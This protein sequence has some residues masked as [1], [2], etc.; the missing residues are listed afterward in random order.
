MSLTFVAIVTFLKKFGGWIGLVVIPTLIK[1]YN[2]NQTEI[3]SI[4]LR[5]QKDA[6]DGLTESEME[7]LAVDIFFE[8]LYPKL[9]FYAKWLPNRFYENKVRQIIKKF[10]EKSHIL[11]GA[12]AIQ[13]VIKQINQPTQIA[14][15]RG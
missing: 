3:Q 9:P 11:K 12:D 8:K 13:E 6:K 7:Q 1:F 4:A 14:G 5:I 15:V 2:D 10:C